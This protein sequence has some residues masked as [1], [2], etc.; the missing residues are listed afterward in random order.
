MSGVGGGGSL[1]TRTVRSL[2]VVLA[3][4]VL[5]LAYQI[6]KARFLDQVSVGIVALGETLIGFVQTFA[7]QGVERAA[8]QVEGDDRKVLNT[9]LCLRLAFSVPCYA[10]L[11]FVAPMWGTWQGG[12]FAAEVT[13][14]VRLVGLNLVIGVVSIVPSAQFTRH[15]LFGRIETAQF[16]AILLSSGLGIYLLWVHKMGYRAVAISAVANVGAYTL[17]VSAMNPAHF[18]RGWDRETARRLL[19]Y[20]KYV[21]AGSVLIYLINYVDNVII[22]S[23]RGVAELGVYAMAFTWGNRV[24]LDFTHVASKVM[25]PTLSRLQSD[26]SRFRGA[27][28]NALRFGAFLVCPLALGMAAV[29]ET[30]VPCVLGATWDPEVTKLLPVLCVYGCLRSFASIHGDALAASGRP[31]LVTLTSALFLALVVPS[32]VL[33]ARAHGALGLTYAFVSVSFLANLFAIVLVR[34]ALAASIGEIAEWILRP[35][36]AAGLMAGGVWGLSRTW[37]GKGWTELGTLVLTGAAL[38]LLGSLLLQRATLRETWGLLR[39]ALHIKTPSVD[40]RPE[41]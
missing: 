36:A 26:P 40:A 35:L 30:F 19:G 1:R 20:G 41:A 32:G 16:S 12:E 5:T 17:F 29:S 37:P 3:F 14:V 8:V 9:A 25:F 21:F 23:E 10:I 6:V 11:W 18:G 39:E 7:D 27:Y 28:L 22:S 34:R 15:L 31:R 13:W 4:R 38:Y 24:V 2:G 33:A